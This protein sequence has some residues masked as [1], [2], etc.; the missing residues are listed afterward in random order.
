MSGVF[1]YAGVTESGKTT[2]AL[3]HMN[4]DI[5]TTD[6]PALILDDMP[7]RNLAH[8][9]HEATPEAVYHKLYNLRET[10]VYT[11]RS[12]DEISDIFAMIHAA[13]TGPLKLKVHVLWDEPVVTLEDG[14]VPMSVYK[15]DG[16]I[17]KALR[18]WQHNG[19]SFRLC[20]QSIKDF[21]GVIF[22]CMPEAYIFRLEREADL[23]RVEEMLKL[24]RD[25][26]EAQGQGVYL[27]YFRNRFR[28]VDH[29]E[30]EK[31]R[32]EEHPA[33]PSEPRLGHGLVQGAPGDEEEDH[34]GHGASGLS[35]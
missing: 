25:Q 28:K 21:H 35:Q 23:D 20:S 6:F 27:T 17:A 30:P 31:P 14:Q 26:V 1:L 5:A 29:A 9:P 4:L 3:E 16:R 8:L 11:P 32:E 7:A 18:G 34:G 22:M 13:G 33:P 15:I 12:V 2:L 19:C 24:D 10:A